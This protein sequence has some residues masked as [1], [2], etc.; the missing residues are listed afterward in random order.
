MGQSSGFFAEGY[1]TQIVRVAAANLARFG[2]GGSPCRAH[3]RQQ[4]MRVPGG[5][6]RGRK[7]RFLGLPHVQSVQPVELGAFQ[8][9]VRETKETGKVNER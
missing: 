6:Y 5:L 1:S 8:L 7:A 3:C 9:W 4:G 2:G